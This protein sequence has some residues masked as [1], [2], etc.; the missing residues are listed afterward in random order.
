MFEL[1]V[2]FIIARFSAA[3]CIP[4]TYF[5]HNNHQIRPKDI[6]LWRWKLYTK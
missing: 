2:G 6:L 5:F 1:S 3:P 4:T